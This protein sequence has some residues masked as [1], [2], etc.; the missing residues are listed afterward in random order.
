MHART[1]PIILIF[2]VMVGASTFGQTESE[3]GSGIEGVILISHIPPRMTRSDV[4]SPA[5]LVDAPFTVTNDNRIVVASFVTDDQGRFRV[6]LGPG[7]YTVSQQDGKSRIRQCG[8]WGADVVA[9]Q[10]T[11]VEWYCETGGHADAKR[12]MP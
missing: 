12:S 8:P 5:A 9:G 1:F 4:P 2:L 6:L 7:R 10:M 11:K 3:S